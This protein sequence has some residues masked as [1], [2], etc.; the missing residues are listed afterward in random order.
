MP[1]DSRVPVLILLTSALTSLLAPAPVEAQIEA[2]EARPIALSEAVRM[3]Q[4]NSPL[5]TQGRGTT[6]VSRASLTSSLSQFLPSVSVG[7]AANHLDGSTSFQGQRVPYAGYPWSYREG[8]TAVVTLFDGGQR[9]FNYRAAQATLRASSETELILRYTVGVNV[10]AQYF[11]S[12]AARE[13][14]A[15]AARQLDAAETLLG[16][17]STRLQAGTANRFDSLRSAA[18]VGA[19]RVAVISARNSLGSAD[20][21]LTRLT[22]STVPLTA[23]VSDTIEVP[24]IN[25]D[26]AL[27]ERMASEGPT[28]RQANLLFSASKS[29]KRASLSDYLPII[30][31]SYNQ[32]AN[33]AAQKFDPWGG[34]FSSTATVYNFTLS[35][36]VF[37]NFLRELNLTQA[38]VD[39]DLAAANL[40][41]ARFAVHESLTRYLSSFHAAIETIELQRLQIIAAEEDLRGQQDRYRAGDGT[42]VE[43]IIAQST[44]DNARLALINARFQARTARAQIE[45]LLGRELP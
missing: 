14:E 27:L 25:A 30:A 33:K 36:P 45:A 9:W 7:T 29:A 4:R 24:I 1:S 34:P 11:A 20:A 19:A 40:R 41:D 32:S 26:S 44:L 17:T 2:R 13:T 3:A 6:R 28:I 8:Y 23:V 43:L 16:L 5:T 38:R 31:M 21:A 37:N 22:A 42:L 15:A 39:E 10:Q 12:L 35:Y 18:L